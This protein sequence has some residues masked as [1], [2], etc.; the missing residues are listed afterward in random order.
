[1]KYLLKKYSYRSNFALRFGM[2]VLILFLSS[3]LF[4]QSP[5]ANYI[6]NGGFE[7]LISNTI[8]TGGFDKVKFWG[9]LDSSQISYYLFSTNTSISNAPYCSTGFQFPRAGNNFVLSQFYA[10]TGTIY[11]RE[12]PRNRLKQNLKPNKTYCAK[13]HVVNTNNNRVAIDKYGMYFGDTS[14]DTISKCMYPITYLNPQVE[15]QNGIIID[16]LNWIAV[17][18]TFVATGNEKYCVLGNFRA[19]SATNTLLIQPALPFN[20]NDVY[21]DD[22]SVIEID[23]PA[24]AGP[25]NWFIPG[26]SVYIGRESDVEIDE[27]CIWYKLTS[28]TTSITID[29]IAGIWVKPAVTSTYVVRQQLWCSGVKWDTVVVSL[30]GVGISEM[31]SILN[32]IQLYPNPASDYVQVQYTLDI[33]NPFTGLSIFNKLGQLIRAEEITFKNKK[34]HVPISELDNG[35][36]FL[37]L[38]NSSGQ[39]VKK[40]FVLAR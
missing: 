37:E 24:Y 12:Y 16:T 33:S 18:G 9:P 19:N 2:G 38:R 26:D 10:D 21:I 22:V 7:T 31:E 28:P 34:V 30:S 17:S 13:Y 40:R 35:L 14:L 29:T 1:M 32:D 15:N 11:P 20:T 25:D 39:T 23:L 3:K 36:Y 6:S 5:I 4:S 27:S 8:T